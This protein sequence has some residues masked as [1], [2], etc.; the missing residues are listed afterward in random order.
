MQEIIIFNDVL[1]SVEEFEKDQ[2]SRS[3]TERLTDCLDS[4]VPAEGK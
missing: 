2:L 4:F 3:E 1:E